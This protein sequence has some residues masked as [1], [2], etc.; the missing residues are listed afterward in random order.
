MF[1][2]AMQAFVYEVQ[3]EMYLIRPARIAMSKFS[4]A[5]AV[6]R[7]ILM[8]LLNQLFYYTHTCVIRNIICFYIELWLINTFMP[9]HV[10]FPQATPTPKD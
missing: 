8:E 3:V 2:Q 7:V 5:P 6:D 4:P 10:N 9:T 1:E